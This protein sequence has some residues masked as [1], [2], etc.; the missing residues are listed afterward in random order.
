MGIIVK[1]VLIGVGILSLYFFI[2]VKI[3]R[4]YEDKKEITNLEE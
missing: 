4:Y 3:V 2:V 1:S